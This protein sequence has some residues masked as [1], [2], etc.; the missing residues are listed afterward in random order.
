MWQHPAAAD[1][2]SRQMTERAR[3]CGA[4]DADAARL[5]HR[6]AFPIQFSRF[7]IGDA[8]LNHGT[9]YVAL[10]NA[11]GMWSNSSLT[12]QE[13]D[14]FIAFTAERTLTKRATLFNC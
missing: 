7:S 9:E 3:H 13:G 14:G 10:S 1:L 11:P 2:T 12:G 4:K 5:A 6:K 8:C